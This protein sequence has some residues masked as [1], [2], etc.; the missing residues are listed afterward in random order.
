MHFVKNFQN[1]YEWRMKINEIKNNKKKL[2]I[3]KKNNFFLSKKFNHKYRVRK[4][5]NFNEI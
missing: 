2:N 3:I 5:F 1:I 4:Y